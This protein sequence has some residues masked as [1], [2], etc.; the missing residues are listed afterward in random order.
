[1]GQN[2]T[3]RL[4]LLTFEDDVDLLKHDLEASESVVVSFI[5]LD[6]LIELQS[7][8]PWLF[9]NFLGLKMEFKKF[10]IL[11][12]GERGSFTFFGIVLNSRIFSG[13]SAGSVWVCFLRFCMW[14]TN[15]FG[16]D[17]EAA[18]SV[19]EHKNML[20]SVDE[21]EFEGKGLRVLLLL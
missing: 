14:K 2:L 11:P 20:E 16:V 4:D 19:S 7:S 15:D 17:L 12:P 5:D 21:Q 6:F 18:E 13:F 1:M 10:A 8:K 3:A 9:F